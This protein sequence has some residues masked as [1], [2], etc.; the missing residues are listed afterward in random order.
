MNVLVIS[1]F[2][3]QRSAQLTAD[4][5]RPDTPKAE[6]DTKEMCQNI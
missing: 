3:L 4:Q 6:L 2:Q 5:I 1:N